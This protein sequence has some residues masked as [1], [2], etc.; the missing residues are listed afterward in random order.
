MINHVHRI[1]KHSINQRCAYIN[2][3]FLSYRRKVGP[4]I[5]STVKYQVQG[6]F[7]NFRLNKK[8]WAALRKAN[9]AKHRVSK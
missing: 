2:F 3:T 7:H 8:K 4:F 9:A 1:V 5:V 6:K